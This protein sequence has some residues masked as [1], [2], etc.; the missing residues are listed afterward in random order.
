MS[1]FAYYRLPDEQAYVSLEQRVG[2]PE[3]LLSVGDLN[4]KQGFVLAPFEPT[5][6]TPIVLLCPDEI[7]KQRVPSVDAVS[8]PFESTAAD[9]ERRAYAAAFT[10]F[11]EAIAQGRF[12]K[13]VLSRRSE[14]T[15]H[16]SEEVAKQLFFSACA[17][18]PHLFIALVATPQSGVWLMAT[19]EILLQNNGNT[20]QTMALA[21]TLK[22]SEQ[23]ENM[24]LGKVEWGEK[25][26]AEQQLVTDYIAECLQQLG[27][28]YTVTA[29][30]TVRAGAL[31]HLRSDFGFA[32][33]GSPQLGTLLDVLHPTPAVCG[34]PKQKARSFILENESSARRYYSGFAG[35]LNMPALGTHLFVTLR[36]ACITPQSMVCYA[37]GGLLAASNEEK[38]WQETQ[39][40]LQTLQALFES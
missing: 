32:L 34:L 3:A 17:R 29:P 24:P 1:A 15:C 11:H 8:L 16:V 22:L 33:D 19:P 40:K 36:C 37:G 18:Y 9:A 30:Y 4:G 2:E 21:G 6:D 35:T 39:A 13:L 5:E 12:A 23:T 26:R 25:E 20:W 38:E 7:K 14:L 10:R 31:A 27:I 28:R